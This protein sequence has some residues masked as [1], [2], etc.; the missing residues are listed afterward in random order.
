M[1]AGYIDAKS[2]RK[3][4]FA[5]FVNNAGP[6]KQLEDVAQVFADEAAITNAIYGSN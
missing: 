5:L 6:I 4:A 3:L 2:G 1:L